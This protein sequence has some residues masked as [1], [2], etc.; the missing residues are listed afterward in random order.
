MEK[1]INELINENVEF[2]EEDEEIK[3]EKE[4]PEI[5]TLDLSI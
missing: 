3:Q 5:Q 1:K 2:V 4:E